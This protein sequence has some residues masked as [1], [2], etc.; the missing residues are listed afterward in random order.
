MTTIALDTETTGLDLYHGARPYLVT[1]AL[2]DGTNRGW[3]WDGD[4]YTRRV[5]YRKG[6]L[7]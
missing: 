5:L 7:R 1:T 3:E 2:E 4:P 6:D